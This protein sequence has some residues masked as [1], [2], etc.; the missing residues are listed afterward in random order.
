MSVL[1]PILANQVQ[2]QC[3]GYS[4]VSLSHLTDQ[5]EPSVLNGSELEVGGA[6]YEFQ[7]DE[8]AASGWAGIANSSSVYMY[9]VPSGA[10]A[11]WIYSTTA[12]TWDTAKQDWVNGL[13]RC[14]GFL[15][16][17]GSGNW[18]DKNLLGAL[19]APRGGRW[20]HLPLDNTTSRV[21]ANSQGSGWSGAIQVAGLFGVPSIARGVRAKLNG[22][23][24]SLAAG[25]VQTVLWFSDNNSNLPSPSTGHPGGY[26]SFIAT[27]A[28]QSPAIDMG[29]KEIP[30]N[31]SGQM[32]A[33]GTGFINANNPVAFTLAAVEYAVGD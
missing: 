8:A 14:F 3:K 32:F 29:E 20:R 22:S 13:N 23:P 31:S 17:D 27:G 6:L 30:L 26:C 9:I 7:A 5:S 18:V 25:L 24:T 28:S 2:K 33:Y 21:I 19:V 4:A 11:T 16:K 15:W 10:S 1:I 12:P